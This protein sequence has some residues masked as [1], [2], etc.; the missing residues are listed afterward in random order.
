VAALGKIGD[1]E[2]EP[3]I[4]AAMADTIGQVRK[5]AAVSCRKLGLTGYE[6]QLVHML[7][8]SFYGARMCASEALLKLDTATVIQTVID[9]VHS[10]NPFVGN[11]GCWVLGRFGNDYAM[12]ELFELSK[13]A[14]YDLRAHAAVALVSADPQDLCSY[15]QRV[16][17]GETDKYILLRIESAIDTSQDGN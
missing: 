16:L 6:P 15:R 8:D 1:K 5:S 17:D 11:L 14:N 4:V 9:S 7:G 2:A 13:E 3:V 12:G 10:P